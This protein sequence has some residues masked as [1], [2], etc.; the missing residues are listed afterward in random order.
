MD[1]LLDTHLAYWYILGYEKMPP[2]A[3]ELI[4]D[5]SNH[6]FVSLVSAWEIG[7]KHAKRPSSMP[8]TSEE[9][10]EACREVGFV[11]L[12][13]V[14]DQLCG[15]MKVECP[16]GLDHQDP[17]DRFL[18]GSAEAMKMRFLTHDAKIACYRE[19]YFLMV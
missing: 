2:L 7:L 1:F 10:L 16:E 14:E 9:F 15:A 4:G 13:I 12:P 3:K 17:F 11:V 18:L 5:R 19:P 6:I 8:M